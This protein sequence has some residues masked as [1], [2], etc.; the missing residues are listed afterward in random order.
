MTVSERRTLFLDMYAAL[1]DSF[2]PMNWWPADTPF[3]VCIGAI[4]TQNAPWEGVRK[5]I[6]ALRGRGLFDSRSIAD[7]EEQELAEAIRPS[8]YYNQ[9]AKKLKS[10]CRFLIRDLDGSIENLRGRTVTEARSLLLSLNGIGRETADSILLYALDMPIFVVDAYTKRIFSRHRLADP[11]WDYD[12]LRMYFED[13]IEPDYR[14]FNEFHAQL[15]RLGADICKKKPKCDIC[16]V[17]KVM[18]EPI[19]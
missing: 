14:F 9:K 17:R 8:I 1:A 4:L 12:E 18:G 3:E 16:P 15:C 6:A 19:V 7:A 2:G 10:F 5:S 13:V 11:N